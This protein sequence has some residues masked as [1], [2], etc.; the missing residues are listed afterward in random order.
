VGQPDRAKDA[1][2]RAVERFRKG[3][4]PDE[5]KAREVEAKIK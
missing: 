2:R 1:W 4:D 3:K 5:E